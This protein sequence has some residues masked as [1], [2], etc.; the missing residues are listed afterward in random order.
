MG[1]SDGS[2]QGDGKKPGHLYEIFKRVRLAALEYIA[3]A[4]LFTAEPKNA[5]KRIDKYR[6]LNLLGRKVT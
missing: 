1:F 3:L 2:S 4:R 6:R 5:R